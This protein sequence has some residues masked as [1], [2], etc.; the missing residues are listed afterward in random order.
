MHGVDGG[1]EGTNFVL[2]LVTGMHRSGTSLLTLLLHEAGLAVPGDLL[3]ANAD[4]PT[5]YWEAREIVRLNNDMLRA[6]GLSWND[7]QAISPQQYD[8]LTVK[9]RRKILDLIHT[10]H[11]SRRGTVFK[12]PRFSRLL[13]V[14]ITVLREHKIAFHIIQTLRSPIEITQ[15]LFRRSYDERFQPAALTCSTKSYCLAAR[16]MLDAEYFTRE[17]ERQFIEHTA[18]LEDPA[19]TIRHCLEKIGV[20]I[21]ESIGVTGTV[22]DSLDKKAKPSLH[23]NKDLDQPA[24]TQSSAVFARMVF[25]TLRALPDTSDATGTMA[26]LD[27]CRRQL[28]NL[29]QETASSAQSGMETGQEDAAIQ[30]SY[31]DIE[32]KLAHQ[33]AHEGEASVQK[34]IQTQKA[35]KRAHITFLSWDPKSRGHIYRI[36]NRI[37]AA[38]S[39]G[40]STSYVTPNDP[41]VLST[42]ARSDMILLF[43]CGWCPHLEKIYSFARSRQIPII[44]DIDDLVFDAQFAT[45]KYLAFLDDL[46]P[47]QTVIWRNNA[48]NLMKAIRNASAVSVS[49]RS[50]ADAIAPHHDKCVVVPNGISAARLQHSEVLLKERKRLR[51]EKDTDVIRIGYAS[52]SATHNRDFKLIVPVLRDLMAKRPQV[53]L[54]LQGEISADRY[55]ELDGLKSRIVHKPMV[56]FSQ[57]PEALIDVDINLAPLETL[58]PFCDAK[59]ELKYFESGLVEVPTIASAT[60]TYTAAIKNGQSSFVAASTQDWMNALLQLVDNQDLRRNMGKMARQESI[61]RWGPAA[62]KRDFLTAVRQFLTKA[63]AQTVA[64]SSNSEIATTMA[65]TSA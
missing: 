12:D 48:H 20:S 62:Q 47:E 44:F 64:R 31:A 28:D 23:R 63:G 52:G 27:A 14:W 10:L 55:S 4:N 35:P 46:D 39:L 36:H 57:L 32:I 58:N 38:Q 50:L 7:E 2:V 1:R 56:P 53:E 41:E 25:T 22:K 17:C 45:P 29:V 13:P 30:T 26:Q 11:D 9:F 65:S 8:D 43:R 3:S 6:C 18:L 59:S 16:Y 49:T 61:I 5:G 54:Y 15:S 33:L 19:G 42:I 37:E 34:F 60:S 21:G 24:F 40:L 51:A